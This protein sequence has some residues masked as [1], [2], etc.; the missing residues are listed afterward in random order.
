MDPRRSDAAGLMQQL[1]WRGA[2]L[3]E[4][5]NNAAGLA[6]LLESVADV[7]DEVGR[8]VEASGGTPAGRGAELVG[9]V[10][11]LADRVRQGYLIL[12]RPQVDALNDLAGP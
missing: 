4:G 1:G 7:L 6:T 11:H 9:E 5:A 12:P 10:R 2:T 3:A 8:H